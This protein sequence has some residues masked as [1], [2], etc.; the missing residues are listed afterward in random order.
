MGSILGRLGLSASIEVGQIPGITNTQIH[1]YNMDGPK[2]C[3]CMFYR[4]IKVRFEFHVR[5]AV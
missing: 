5:L 4:N 2:Y 3:Y 1:T